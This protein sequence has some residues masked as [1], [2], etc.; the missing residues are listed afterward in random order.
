MAIFGDLMELVYVLFWAG[1]RLV[2]LY[3]C[4]LFVCSD[5]VFVFSMVIVL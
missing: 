3:I 4:V 5:F 2:I 1:R